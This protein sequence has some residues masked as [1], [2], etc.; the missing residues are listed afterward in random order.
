LNLRALAAI[1]SMMPLAPGRM[2]IRVVL[3]LA[4]L[5]GLGAFLS[6]T[7]RGND[8]RELYDRFFLYLPASSFLLVVVLVATDLC[9]GLVDRRATP[10]VRVVRTAIVLATGLTVAA[11]LVVTVL[12]L[13]F[14]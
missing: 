13:W 7:G 9:L 14:R 6:A 1:I 10:D 11:V 4:G 12:L 2:K 8:Q 3:M 5:V